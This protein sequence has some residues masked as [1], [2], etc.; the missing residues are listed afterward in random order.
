MYESLENA[1]VS[2]LL[3]VFISEITSGSNW[4]LICFERSIF[5]AVGLS[6]DYLIHDLCVYDSLFCISITQVLLHNLHVCVE[7]V[8]HK[9]DC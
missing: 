6:H 9:S 3:Q 8:L 7:H 4:W 2:K 1:A 5:M